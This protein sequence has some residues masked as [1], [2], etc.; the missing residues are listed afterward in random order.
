MRQSNY[1]HVDAGSLT[2][3]YAAVFLNVFILLKSLQQ[4]AYSVLMD[5]LT[6]IGDVFVQPRHTDSTKTIATEISLITMADCAE[7]S[8]LF[9]IPCSLLT[10][11]LVITFE[12]QGHKNVCF[13]LAFYYLLIFI[14]KD[15][16]FRYARLRLSTIADL[17]SDLVTSEQEH[18]LPRPVLDCLTRHSMYF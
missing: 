4:K 18:K 16:F 7:N 12:G 1:C 15:E 3:I 8:D 14:R 11:M 5:N 10:P 2:A 13:I 17:Y 6:V 9:C